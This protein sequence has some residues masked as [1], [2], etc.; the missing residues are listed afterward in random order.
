MMDEE[1]GCWK[2]TGARRGCLCCL[3]F[4]RGVVT[5]GAETRLTCRFRQLVMVCAKWVHAGKEGRR[6]VIGFGESDGIRY[7]YIYIYIYVFC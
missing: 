5:E 2:H 6:R 3:S 4:E 7:I 1:L